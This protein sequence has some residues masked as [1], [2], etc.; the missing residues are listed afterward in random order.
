MPFEKK[1]HKRKLT[2]STSLNYYARGRPKN[3]YKSF[4]HND[5]QNTINNTVSIP[6]E[7][8]HNYSYGT[9]GK[10]M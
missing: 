9:F 5:S 8:K 4:K 2:T 10:Y 7:K 6:C 3:N 1:T